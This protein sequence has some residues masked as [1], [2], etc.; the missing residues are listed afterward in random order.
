MIDGLFVLVKAKVKKRGWGDENA[1][2]MKAL[3]KNDFR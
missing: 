1:K 3:A 2:E